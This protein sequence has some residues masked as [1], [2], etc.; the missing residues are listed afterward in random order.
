MGTGINHNA[1]KNL[2]NTLTFGVDEA[3]S[4]GHLLF[5]QTILS[6]PQRCWCMKISSLGTTETSLSGTN[7]WTSADHIEH[8]Y[9]PKCPERLLCDELITERLARC[10]KWSGWWAKHISNINVSNYV[11]DWVYIPC[12][13]VIRVFFSYNIRSQKSAQFCLTNNRSIELVFALELI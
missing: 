1:M 7:N 11:A 2:G 9:V 10:S 13:N 6:K 4:A 3:F 8:V 12:R 5:F